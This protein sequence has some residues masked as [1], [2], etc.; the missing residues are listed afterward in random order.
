MNAWADYFL[1]ART[2]AQRLAW[3]ARILASAS[4]LSGLRARFFFFLAG[5]AVLA[6][7]VVA[8]R[9]YLRFCVLAGALEV[10]GLLGAL[11]PPRIPASSS[12]SASISSLISA[13]R[14]REAALI[15]DR[16]EFD[17]G[18]LI[19]GIYRNKQATIFRQPRRTCPH[20]AEMPL[21][22]A[23]ERGFQ[24]LSPRKHRR[25]RAQIRGNCST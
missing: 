10:L 7:S 16:S 9:V 14:R 23:F 8:R 19:I 18:F 17:I 4:G 5:A 11:E 1:P 25:Y 21:S 24:S 3:A 15:L 2:L 6:A 13:A 12:R 20:S 22:K